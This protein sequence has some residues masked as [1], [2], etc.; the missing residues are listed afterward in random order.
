MAD[1]KQPLIVAKQ[2]LPAARALE[3]FKQLTKSAKGRTAFKA[4]PSKA[5]G[6]HKKTLRQAHLRR[7]RYSDIPVNS[8]KALEALSI[9]E[10]EL[11]SNLDATFVK[12]GL[13]VEVPNPGSLHYH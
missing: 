3:V 12:D 2:N 13:Y 9:Y 10:L 1:R 11:L 5:F 4:S 6:E 7:A 8:R